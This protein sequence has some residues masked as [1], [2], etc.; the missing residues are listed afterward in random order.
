MASITI[1]KVGQ[2]PKHEVKPE[3]KQGATRKHKTYPRSSLKNN[4]ITKVSDP[5]KSPKRKTSK[6][7]IRLSTDKGTRKRG[8]TVKH[9]VGKMSDEKIRQLVAKHKLVMNSKTP[10][11]LQREMVEGGILSGFISEV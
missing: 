10:M 1:T 5:A 2:D 4:A 3:G 7:T 6:H 8:K 9:K 11:S